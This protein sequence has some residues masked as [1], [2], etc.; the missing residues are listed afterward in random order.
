MLARDSHHPRCPDED[1]TQVGL[2][3]GEEVID[4]RQRHAVE[5]L[6][7]RTLTRTGAGAPERVSSGLAVKE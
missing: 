4:H 3:V 5:N 7:L 1:P 2:I 6:D